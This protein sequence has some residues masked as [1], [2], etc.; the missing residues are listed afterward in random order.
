MIMIGSRQSMMDVDNISTAGD[1]EM[2]KQYRAG[3]YFVELLVSNL[4]LTDF[5]MFL[6]LRVVVVELIRCL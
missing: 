3:L 4:L 5:P 1:N 2:H 6:L